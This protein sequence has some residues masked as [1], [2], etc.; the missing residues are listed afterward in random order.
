MDEEVERT[1]YLVS[2]LEK[3]DG[4]RQIGLRPKEH[5]LV[6]FETPVF[7]EIA[8]SHPRRGFFLYEELKKRRIVGIRRGQTRWFKCSVYGMTDR[9]V[10]YIIDSFREIVEENRD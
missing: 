3:M 9:Q 7:H 2:E 4:V 5:D 6:R 8:S 10:Q 1:R